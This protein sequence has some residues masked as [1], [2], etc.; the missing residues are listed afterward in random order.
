[1]TLDIDAMAGVLLNKPI[2]DPSCNTVTTKM[3]RHN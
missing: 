3:V 1:M 2:L